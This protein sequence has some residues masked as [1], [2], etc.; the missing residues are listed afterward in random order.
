MSA[1]DK[2]KLRAAERAEKLTE[3]QLAEQ[4]EAK[5]LK[6]LTTVFV[7]ALALMLCFAIVITAVKTVENSGI[8]ERNTVALTLDDRQINNAE[9]NY[10]FID[11]LNTFLNEN[12]TIIPYL[13][14]DAT[15]P[16]DEQILDEATGTTWADDF[17]TGAVENA[18]AAYALADAAAEAGFVLTEEDKT[19]IE[20]TIANIELS[21]MVNYGYPDLK[22]YLKAMY[23]NGAD[24]ESFRA[25]RE[26]NYLAES[27][28][29][30]YAEDLTYE[31]ADLR[32]AEADNYD[33]YSSYTYNYY[34]L[35][36]NSLIEG[37]DTS[38]PTDE[39][40]ADAVALAEEYAKSLTEGITTVE[41]FDAAVAA[42][43][44]NAEVENAASNTSKDVSY[45][46]VNAVIADW[47]T[48]SARKAGDITYIPGVSTST[49]EAGNETSKITGYYAVLFG[50]CNE[51]NFSLPNVRHILVA[52]EGG[53]LDENGYKIYSDTE[54][55]TAKLAAEKL[56]NTW[57]NGDATEESFATLANE[58][59]D[60]SD[61]TDGGL[62]TNIVPGQMVANFNDWC[63]DDSRKVGDT[64][65]VE[66][67]YGYHV[68]YFCGESERTYRDLMIENEL[69]VAAVNAWFEE[70]LSGITATVVDPKYVSTD[71]V[72]STN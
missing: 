27:Y 47:V 45:G 41:E 36:V 13:G 68:M 15:K 19:N 70:L 1:S 26:L 53:T 40:Y 7:V 22:T 65:I 42:L 44:M 28:Q 29:A 39:Q 21:A 64:D 66:T 58:N 48:D 32:E 67:E 46:A 69:K 43:P 60:D 56:L 10:F 12:S 4:K 50:G 31:D 25:Y 14:L 49:D 37:E 23:G 3:K 11:G 72:L 71:L 55:N 59:S 9:L 30:K 6:I 35:N 33:A 38:N 34:Y 63:F 18:K 8:R 62:Y 5:K 51:N 24:E 57:K 61:G 52:F 2:K 20:A 54:K 16:L 17:M